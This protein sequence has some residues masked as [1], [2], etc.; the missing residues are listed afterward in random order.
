MTGAKDNVNHYLENILPVKVIENND[1][2]KD[3]KIISCKATN[4]KSLDGFLSTIF[5]IHLVLEDKK[6]KR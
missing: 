4:S 6:S 2:L 1:E 3:C 5:L